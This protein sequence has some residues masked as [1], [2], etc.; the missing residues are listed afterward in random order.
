[1]FMLMFMFMFGLIQ[2]TIFS[3]VSYEGGNVLNISNISQNLFTWINGVTN[4]LCP[5]LFASIFHSYRV[6]TSIFIKELK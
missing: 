5:K 3:A 4:I 1:M 6:M 2:D